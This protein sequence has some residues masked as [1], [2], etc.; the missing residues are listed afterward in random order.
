MPLSSLNV[1]PNQECQQ[2]Q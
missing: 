2:W 1:Q